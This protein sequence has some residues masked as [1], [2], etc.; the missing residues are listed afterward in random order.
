MKKKNLL[1]LL[2]SITLDFLFFLLVFLYFYDIM[3]MNFILKMEMKPIL[4]K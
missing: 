2:I 1:I 3:H 4:L